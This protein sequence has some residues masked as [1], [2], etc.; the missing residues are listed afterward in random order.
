MLSLNNSYIKIVQPG[1]DYLTKLF[2]KKY[3][4]ISIPIPI[5]KVYEN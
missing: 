1:N 4:T 3:S 2:G 5:K